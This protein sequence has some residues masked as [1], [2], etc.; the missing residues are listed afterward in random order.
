MLIFRNSYLNAVLSGTKIHKVI[1]EARNGATC[2]TYFTKCPYSLNSI[3]R[4]LADYAEKYASL[5]ENNEHF[6]DSFNAVPLE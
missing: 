5:Q 6:S 1:S 2:D 3:N 4:S